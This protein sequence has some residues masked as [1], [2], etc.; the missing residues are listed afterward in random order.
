MAQGSQEPQEPPAPREKS[1]GLL[2][3]PGGK[4]PPKQPDSFG[5]LQ[6]S[7]CLEW[8][9]TEAFNKN[10]QQTTGFNYACK[11]CMKVKTRKYNLP[12][13]YGITAF[14]YAQKITFQDG[15]CACCGL[16]FDME[17]KKSQRPCVDHNHKTGEVR[18][19]LCGRCNLAAGNVG[20]SSAMAEK[21]AMYL[22]KWNC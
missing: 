17:G 9:G 22:K 21:I 20:D 18:D 3:F 11:S 10:K 1:M 4:R 5:R 12:A 8:K 2:K 15:R 16:E 7:S 6:C 14:E 19:I 13:K